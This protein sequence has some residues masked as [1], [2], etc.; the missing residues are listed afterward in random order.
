MQAIKNPNHRITYDTDRTQSI[1]AHLRNNL[2]LLTILK[3]MLKNM[4]MN[5][6]VIIWMHLF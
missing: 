1:M 2:G 5:A 6:S 3:S 4:K